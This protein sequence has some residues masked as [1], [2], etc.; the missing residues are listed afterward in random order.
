MTF[1]QGSINYL[2]L[3]EHIDNILLQDPFLPI[4][5]LPKDW[6]G[7]QILKLLTNLHDLIGNKLRQNS[8]YYKFIK[9]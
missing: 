7:N 5:L 2:D 4:P 8:R 1:I 6:N 9:K 3:D